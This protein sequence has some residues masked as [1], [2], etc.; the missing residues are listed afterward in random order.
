M[1]FINAILVLIIIMT[2]TAA[3]EEPSFCEYVSQLWYDGNKTAVLDI[4][5]QRLLENTNDIAGLLLKMEYEMEFLMFDDMTN[6]MNRVLS[7]SSQISTTNFVQIYPFLEGSITHLLQMIPL[8]PTNE[9]SS[10]IS[11]SQLS[12]KRLSVQIALD[13]LAED[14][15]FD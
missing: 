3:A 14:G 12:G 10:D 9:L 7:E 8:Y 2:T 4:A 5:N 6:S 11:K 13:A 15:Y 1:K